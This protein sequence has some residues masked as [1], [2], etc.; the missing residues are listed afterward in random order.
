MTLQ[1]TRGRESTDAATQDGEVCCSSGFMCD[2][3]VTGEIDSELSRAPGERYT[4]A[5]VS[6]V[7]NKQ[8]V[9]EAL[10]VDHEAGRSKRSQAHNFTNDPVASDFN[11][12]K[13]ALCV[14]G[15]R[16]SRHHQRSARDGGSA[17]KIA[18]IN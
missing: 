1:K 10:C 6:V 7:V 9:S 2:Q 5:A 3:K 16:A 17:Q 15:D 18:S 4:A 14:E 12:S 8:L 11:R 13:V